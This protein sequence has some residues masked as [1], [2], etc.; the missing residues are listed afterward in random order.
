MATKLQRLIRTIK[1]TGSDID[2]FFLRN[3]P[4]ADMQ[5]IHDDP[6]STVSM[7]FSCITTTARAIS[8]VPL[9]VVKYDERENAIPVKPSHP[10]QKLFNRPNYMSSRGS[11]LEAVISHW[12][13][14]GNVCIIPFPPMGSGS[15]VP[16]S[17]WVAKWKHM[18]FTKDNNGH[19]TKWTY[20]PGT[21]ASAVDLM[22][23]EVLHLRFF[24][25]NDPI[26]GMA[27]HKAGK[28]SIEGVYKSS[29][30]NSMFFDNGA[31]PGGVLQTDKQLSK[32]TFDRT[33]E[34]VNQDYG[35]KT[36]QAHRMMVLEQGLKYQATG[37]SQRDMEFIKLQGLS[38][39]AIMQ[40]Y[41]MKKT[42][43]SITG[44]VNHAT[45]LSERK[46]WWHGTCMALMSLL[47]DTLTFGLF[48]QRGIALDLR[49]DTSS[50]DALHEAFADKTKTAQALLNLGFT[51]N[52]V[53]SRLELGF[54]DV[55][56][57]NIAY[58]PVNMMPVNL[59][60]VTPGAGGPGGADPNEP[61]NPNNPQDNPPEATPAP[62]A[63]PPKTIREQQLAHLTNS[64]EGQLV[65]KLKRVLF[66]MRK[67]TL[68]VNSRLERGFTPM[69]INYDADK[70]AI[71]RYATPILSGTVESGYLSAVEE[72]DTLTEEFTTPTM[73]ITDYLLQLPHS[74]IMGFV[75][76]VMA[77]LQN[78]C[79]AAALANSDMGRAIRDAF[80]HAMSKAKTIAHKEVLTAFNFGRQAGSKL[81]EVNE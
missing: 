16:Q 34:Q 10:W 23:N 50:I 68:E 39:E 73:V 53:N 19:L 40:I 72:V 14:D 64:F 29:I 42:I 31:V 55:K 24:N 2:R 74:P 45:A 20:Q 44:S 71:A 12:M 30:Y 33:K 1:D 49:F 8:Q 41:G 22:P 28:L 59:P 35:V 80:N 38:N 76:Y 5:R 57:G 79:S 54:D 7:V 11:F 70:V 51:R 78:R 47:I 37:I 25:P 21:T 46:E 66:D 65:G 61:P 77:D 58:M 18:R 63:D 62:E 69:M 15:G 3:M 43:L 52:E 60:G 81:M 36:G 48:E 13:L 56:W 27:P 17:L 4:I 9:M 75:N 32:T 6:Y 67:N 26:E